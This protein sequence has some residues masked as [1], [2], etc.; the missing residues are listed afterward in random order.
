[1]SFNNVGQ[2]IAQQK[3]WD[4][5]GNMIPV[6]EHSEGIRPHGEYMPAAWLPVKFFEK[7]YEN[8]I[9]VMPGKAVAL[10]TD[11][12]LVPAQYGLSGAT[13]TYTTNDVLAGVIDVRTGLPLL[14]GNVGTFNV[15]DVSNFM[16][17]GNAMAV[18]APVGVAP[19]PYIQWAGDGSALDDGNNPAAYR[20]NNYNMQHRSAI[21]CDYVLELPIVPAAQAAA[22]I[23]KSA[24]DATNKI[25]TFNAVANLPVA[26]NTVRTPTTFSN[27]TQTDAAA[28]FV[29]QVDSASLIKAAGDWAVNLDTGVISAYRASDPGSGNIYQVAYYHYASAPT[30]AGV[31]VFASVLGD[32]QPG[33]FLKVNADS[34]YVVDSS[35]SIDQTMGQVLD[36]E[37]YPRDGLGRVR[38]AYNN[39]GTNA[40]GSLPGY[41]GQM[42]Q[43]PGS[44]TGG[45]SDKIHYA[46][47][48]N[49][50]CR[51]NLISR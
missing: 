17:R 37:L 46:G 25:V 13:V 43:M 22:N 35:P 15:A 3:P 2:F 20:F 45:V 34:N 16:G 23:T 18:S 41:A 4:H 1:M 49:K 31:S 48:A 47:A 51:V 32:V 8:W 14:S 6:V 44:A 24:Y 50:V 29:N 11:G 40:A 42:D 9:T 10:D 28:V 12:R 39:I 21:L 26:Q 7:F 33:D 30:G 19:Y 5:V 36:I 27:G 38:T